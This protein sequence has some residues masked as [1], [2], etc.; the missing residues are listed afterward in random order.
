MRIVTI[1]NEP[2]ELYKILKFE[3]FAAS[4]GEAKYMIADGLV[5]LNGIV[6]TQ[7]RKKIFQGDQI[8]IGDETLKIQKQR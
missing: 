3:N 6:E 4:G 5:R 2:V 1:K 8:T 7:K